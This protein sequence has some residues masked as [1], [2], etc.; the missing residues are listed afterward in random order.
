MNEEVRLDPRQAPA[1]A[2]LLLAAGFG[3]EARGRPIHGRLEARAQPEPTLPEFPPRDA[4]EAGR[5]AHL[6]TKGD[7]HVLKLAIAADPLRGRRDHESRP[8]AHP[9]EVRL[10]QSA[11]P[12]AAVRPSTPTTHLDP[13]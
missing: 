4:R 10:R 2:E 13:S 3:Q 5:A 7:S 1:R 9:E 11:L 6:R 8:A 12:A